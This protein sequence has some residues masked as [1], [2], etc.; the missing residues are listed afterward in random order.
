MAENR[1]GMKL[2]TTLNEQHKPPL[3]AL[4]AEHLVRL[5]PQGRGIRPADLVA[6]LYPP[7]PQDQLDAVR[8]AVAALTRTEDRKPPEAIRIGRLFGRFKGVPLPGGLQIQSAAYDTSRNCQLWTATHDPDAVE[9]ECSG[10]EVAAKPAKHQVAD[11]T[12]DC[13]YRIERFVG[14]WLNEHRMSLPEQPSA[15]DVISAAGSDPTDVALRKGRFVLVA[16]SRDM[17]TDHRLWL[18]AEHWKALGDARS[19]GAEVYVCICNDEPGYLSFQ[20]YETF[21]PHDRT[22]EGDRIYWAVDPNAWWIANFK[23]VVPH[24]QSLRYTVGPTAQSP[25]MPGMSRFLKMLLQNEPELA[26]AVQRGWLLSETEPEA[27]VANYWAQRCEFEAAID[28]Y[29]CVYRTASGLLRNVPTASVRLD[30]CPAGL[31]FTEH[32]LQSTLDKVAELL[33][34]TNPELARAMSE[35]DRITI[36]GAGTKTGFMATPKVIAFTCNGSLAQQVGDLLYESA[37]NIRPKRLR[38]SN[39]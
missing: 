6:S 2:P 39:S 25:S 32:Q 37:C 24:I 23:H 3:V 27:G 19:G 9:A 21:L 10:Q 22:I 7:K 14:S 38:P 31:S 17:T 20:S 1:I 15:F 35:Q 28:L 18:P 5:D 29:V 12:T 8:S 16:Y 34:P 26:A 4:L 36:S 33:L 11:D 30:L 13:R